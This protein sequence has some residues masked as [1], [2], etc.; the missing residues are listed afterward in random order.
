MT[1]LGDSWGGITHVGELGVG[2]KR[3]FF[4][5]HPLSIVYSTCQARLAARHNGKGKF[6]DGVRNGRFPTSTIHCHIIIIWRTTY[7]PAD[8]HG[9]VANISQ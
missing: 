1:R 3:P 8:V 7:I 9:R 5:P 4:P 6:A 2:K